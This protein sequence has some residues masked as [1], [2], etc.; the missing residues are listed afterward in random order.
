MRTWTCFPLWC[1]GKPV[2]HMAALAIAE[3]VGIGPD[4]PV[5]E[6]LPPSI[7]EAV[8]GLRLRD[9]SCHTGG[10]HAIT[11][12][13]VMCTDP[14]ERPSLAKR[15]LASRQPDLVSG[16]GEVL[17]WVVSE[18][19]LEHH[20]GERAG[21]VLDS[22]LVDAGVYDLHFGR[23]PVADIGWYWG[24][25]GD[26]WMPMLGHAVHSELA[27]L[28]PSLSGIGSGRGLA[29]WYWRLS[30][31]ISGRVNHGA[32]FP[33]QAYLRDA[34]SQRD[35]RQDAVL[36]RNCGFAAGLASPLGGNRG[37]FGDALLGLTG[38]MGRVL[39]FLDID[40]SA[41][42]AVVV[43]GIDF[44]RPDGIEE[45]RAELMAA[46]LGEVGHDA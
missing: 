26:D 30:E 1:A 29:E 5:A 21:T 28:T 14:A 19:I 3:Q 11:M 27:K 24:E 20:T 31:V 15:G 13:E 9:L 2:L 18:A 22:L 40:Q 35:E 25:Q 46:M 10:L 45:S 33:S 32:L 34:L 37:S 23:F 12:A 44:D 17:P 41:A 16:Y 38:W 39:G 42:G 7:A 4:D 36:R 8:T 43:N 6:L